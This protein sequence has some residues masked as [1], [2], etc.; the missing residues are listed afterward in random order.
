MYRAG[1]SGRGR[2]GRP[3][4]FPRLPETSPSEFRHSSKALL[5]AGPAVARTS[6]RRNR[7]KICDCIMEI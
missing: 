7:L 3:H 4:P 5:R 6:V 1:V 2:H